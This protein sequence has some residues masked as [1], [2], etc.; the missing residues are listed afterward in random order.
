MIRDLTA[1][2]RAI[3][4]LAFFIATLASAMDDRGNQLS[5]QFA[6]VPALTTPVAEVEQMPLLALG[7]T[8]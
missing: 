4:I 3:V 7:E 6:P 2:Q 1:W 8:R 5:E